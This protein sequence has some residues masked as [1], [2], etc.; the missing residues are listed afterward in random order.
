MKAINLLYYC[1]GAQE[2]AD[3]AGPFTYLEDKKNSQNPKVYNDL[4]TI[5]QRHCAKY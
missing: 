5:Y 3:M 4:K 2:L 1:I